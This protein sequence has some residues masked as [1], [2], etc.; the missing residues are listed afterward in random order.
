MQNVCIVFRLPSSA[1]LLTAVF[2][3]Y[4][5]TLRTKF[6]QTNRQRYRLAP[7]EC[8][9]QFRDLA[10]QSGC[11]YPS[12]IPAPET[13]TSV[14][15]LDQ[16]YLYNLPMVK[17]PICDSNGNLTFPFLTTAIR[18]LRFGEDPDEIE[19]NL[20]MMTFPLMIS[21]PL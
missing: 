20:F 17:K 2:G 15:H 9:N 4:Y 16:E 1:A 6:D 12:F 19:Q 14:N 3:E 21:L 10:M 13:A 5:S 8:K 7:E 18:A 11:E